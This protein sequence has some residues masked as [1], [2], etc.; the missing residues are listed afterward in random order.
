LANWNTF[1]NCTDCDFKLNGM[2]I[3]T[4]FNCWLLQNFFLDSFKIVL[5]LKKNKCDLHFESVE[6]KPET[7]FEATWPNAVA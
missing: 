7:S 3:L 6:P 1:G 4:L 2:A 5:D